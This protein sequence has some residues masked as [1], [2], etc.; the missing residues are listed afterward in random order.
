MPGNHIRGQGELWRPVR[1]FNRNL[2]YSDCKP[3]LALYHIWYG[4][5]NQP[6]EDNDEYLQELLKGWLRDEK[7]QDVIC[8]KYLYKVFDKKIDDIPFIKYVFWG[9]GVKP[10]DKLIYTGQKSVIA[11]FVRFQNRGRGGQKLWDY[12]NE[13]I[14]DRKG[15]T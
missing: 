3:N 2:A 4:A 9:K 12:Y 1:I 10:K 6:E 11:N 14:V 15:K 5:F 8:K 7:V 13:F